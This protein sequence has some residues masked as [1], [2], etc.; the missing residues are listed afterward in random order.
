MD[1]DFEKFSEDTV[2]LYCI[3]KQKL[4]RDGCND[5]CASGKCLCLDSGQFELLGYLEGIVDDLAIGEEGTFE[6]RRNLLADRFFCSRRLPQKKKLVNCRPR[7]TG[8]HT[9]IK[10]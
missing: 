4:V 6:G 8:R 10:T 5:E 2:Y 3:N 9:L 7:D 1:N